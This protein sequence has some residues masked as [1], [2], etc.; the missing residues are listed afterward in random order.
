MAGKAHLKI[1]FL[2]KLIALRYFKRSRSSSGKKTLVLLKLDAIGDYLIFRNF[3]A[4]FKKSD[5][6]KDH[7]ITLIGNSI[8]RDLAIY[9]DGNIVDNFI[10]VNVSDRNNYEKRNRIL[11]MVAALEPKDVLINCQYSRNYLSDLI[12]FVVKARTKIAFKGDTYNNRY[13]NLANYWYHSLIELKSYQVHEFFKN[14]DFASQVIGSEIDLSLPHIRLS[15]AQK[16]LPEYVNYA[17]IAP[18]AGH[19]KRQ[20]G[21][22]QW[23]YVSAEL[24]NRGYTLCF[25]GTAQETAL[26]QEIISGLPHGASAIDLTGKTAF[27]ELIS[28][29]NNSELV[30]CNDSSIY[31]MAV[32]LNKP[33][34]CFAGGGHFNR[35]VNYPPSDTIILLSTNLTCFNCNWNCIYK[36]HSNDP[37]YC[38]SHIGR[39]Q[40]SDALNS[41]EKKLQHSR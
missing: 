12:S 22:D 31:H 2:F 13:I 37:Y 20:A 11:E 5:R 41:M 36:D 6:F 28:L 17:V 32:G 14:R 38:I 21:K 9:L 8:W 25:A 29:V 33:V 15:D 1:F 24:V 34:I 23:I 40:I 3:I 30:M 35:F 39:Q 18:G 27:P 16:E 19:I 26:A 10:W 4:S 7:T